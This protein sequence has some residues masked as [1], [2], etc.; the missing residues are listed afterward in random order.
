M[1]K[2]TNLLMGALGV[3]L[4]VGEQSCDVFV[5]RGEFMSGSLTE[6]LLF[7]SQSGEVREID[8]VLLDLIPALLNS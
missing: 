2:F 1:D 7:M 8:V 4:R 5:L 3:V 6:L